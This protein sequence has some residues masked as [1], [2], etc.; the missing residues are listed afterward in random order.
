MARSFSLDSLD[1]RLARTAHTLPPAGK[2][3]DAVKAKR[4]KSTHVT[5]VPPCLLRLRHLP[6]SGVKIRPLPR[7]RTN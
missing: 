3:C 4:S 5:I 2:A 6:S 1:A 7:R